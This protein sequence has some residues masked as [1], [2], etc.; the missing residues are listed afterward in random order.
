MTEV[1]VETRATGGGDLGGPHLI[2]KL[3][4]RLPEI[5]DAIDEVTGTLRDRFRQQLQDDDRTVGRV[6]EIEMK[7]SLDLQAEAGV[8]VSRATVAAGFEV[9]IKWSR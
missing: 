7:F 8:I 5:A 4:E 9:T 6:D 2:S 1:L 3:S